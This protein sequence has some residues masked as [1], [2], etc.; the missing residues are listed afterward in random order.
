MSGCKQCVKI[1]NSFSLLKLIL[2]GCPQGSMLGPILF[3][4]FIND[5]FFLLGSDLHNFADDNIITA[6]AETIQGLINS[7]E[8]KTSN[9]IKWMKDNDMIANPD[10]FKAIMLTK[11]D[12]NTAG[13]RLEFS[14][15]TILSNNEID[16]LGITIDT[17]LSFDPHI[18][19]ICHKASR[20]LNALKRLGFYI[21]L[22]TRKIPLSNSFIISNFNHCPLVWYFSMAKQLQK[23][24]KYRKGFSD[25]CTMIMCQII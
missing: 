23:I 3:N 16:F 9:A 12:H 4:I 21:P 7:L 8:V 17:K 5:T 14:G 20:Q 10:K 22:D 24:E 2:S 11:T 15:E 25:F 6:V 19:K 13:I 18:A 1:R